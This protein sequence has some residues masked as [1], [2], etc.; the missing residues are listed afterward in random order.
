MLSMKNIAELSGDTWIPPLNELHFDAG[1]HVYSYNGTKI[2]SVT[3]ILGQTPRVFGMRYSSDIP[4][5]VLQRA[6]AKGTAIHEYIEKFYG[7]DISISSKNAELQSKHWSYIA[8]FHA[9]DNEHCVRPLYQE[10][11]THDG[12]TYAGTV[13]FVAYV[14][15][16]LTIVD[17]KTQRSPSLLKWSLQLTAYKK[18]VEAL[19]GEKVEVVAILHICED[20]SYGYYTLP[21]NERLWESLLQYVALTYRK[22]KFDMSAMYDIVSLFEPFVTGSLDI[23]PFNGYYTHEDMEA[24]L[25]D[26]LYGKMDAAHEI[27]HELE[28]HC[29]SERLMRNVH[30]RIGGGAE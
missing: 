2:P 12:L 11:R 6:A 9:W 22:D 28:Q 26:V 4:R 8:A 10:V 17:W 19:I 24:V 23:E 14:D 7:S 18:T 25:D 1:D 15:D 13:D 16:K 27:E 3:T 30:E 21:T 29:A 5:F 20:G